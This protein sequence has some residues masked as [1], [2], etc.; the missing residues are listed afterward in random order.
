MISNKYLV[1]VFSCVLISMIIGESSAQIV[2]AGV[3]G[4]I[5]GMTSET[6]GT[7]KRPYNL[8]LGIPYANEPQRFKP[9]ELKEELLTSPGGTFLAQSF[10]NMCPQPSGNGLI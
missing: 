1:V 4:R 7:V 9:T 6:V 2:D 8:F 5:Q 3:L 10:G